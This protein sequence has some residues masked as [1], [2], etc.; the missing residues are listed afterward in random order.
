[1]INISFY[2]FLIFTF[3]PYVGLS[4][5][6]SDVQPLS[7]LSAIIFLTLTAKNYEISIRKDLLI[8]LLIPLFYQLHLLFI[9]I[10]LFYPLKQ[11]LVIFQVY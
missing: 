11:F 6:P 2:F 9:V 3:I 4:I 5:I 8:I 10:L 1:M 7:C